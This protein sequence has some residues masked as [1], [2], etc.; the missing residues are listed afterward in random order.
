MDQNDSFVNMAPQTI[1]DS[2]GDGIYVV[3]RDRRIVY[4]GKSAAEIT[5]WKTPTTQSDPD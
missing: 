1:L 2:L 3:D 4:W 5:G